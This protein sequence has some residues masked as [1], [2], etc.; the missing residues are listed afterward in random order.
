MRKD[1]ID[2]IMDNLAKNFVPKWFELLKW[3]FTFVTITYIY[4][5]TGN[6]VVFIIYMVSYALLFL[7]I[8]NSIVE[9]FIKL[10]KNKRYG[11]LKAC[12]ISVILSVTLVVVVYYFLYIL[13]NQLVSQG[14][15]H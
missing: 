2:K 8:L 12:I 14:L 4:K 11:R 13:A 7:S 3:F 15:I 1:K 6:I 5:K 9:Q 10:L